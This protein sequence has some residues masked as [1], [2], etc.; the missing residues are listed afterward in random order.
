MYSS[1]SNLKFEKLGEFETKFKN[2]LGGLSGPK[3]ELFYE[4]TGHEKSRDFVPLSRRL[5]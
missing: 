1:E 2:I 5:G 4:K 3:M